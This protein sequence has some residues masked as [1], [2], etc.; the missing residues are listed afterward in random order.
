MTGR[1]ARR[2][3]LVTSAFVLI[4]ASGLGLVTASRSVIA[5]GTALPLAAPGGC[6]CSSITIDALTVVT[7]C[8][9]GALQCVVTSAAA[10]SG[11]GPS[12]SHPSPNVSCVK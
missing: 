10:R 1:N 11:E 12:R 9:C 8:Q 3:A 4:L 5:Q 6:S 2:I 7:H